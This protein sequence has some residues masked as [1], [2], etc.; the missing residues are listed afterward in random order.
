MNRIFLR[1][2]SMP[3]TVKGV[4]IPDAEGDYTVFINDALCPETRKRVIEHEMA[5]IR[6]NHFSDTLTV[7]DAERDAG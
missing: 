7:E 3:M 1:L 6:Q 5:H 4:T 2:A